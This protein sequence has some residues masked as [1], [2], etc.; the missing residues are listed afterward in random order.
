MD[1]SATIPEL[2][3]KVENDDAYFRLMVHTSIVLQKKRAEGANI[4]GLKAMHENMRAKSLRYIRE[5]NDLH[6]ESHAIRFRIVKDFTPEEL[7]YLIIN[8]QEELYTSSYTNAAKQ[9]LYD[10]M[11]LRMKP[12]AETV[13]SCW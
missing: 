13:S 4:M 9:G 12:P 8:G 7:Y 10:Q 2:E 6:D 11:M 3:R 1:G 5:I